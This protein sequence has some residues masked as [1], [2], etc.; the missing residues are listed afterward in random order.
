MAFSI[1]I[2][3]FLALLLVLYHKIKQ[4]LFSEY[5]FS[6][7]FKKVE[8]AQPNTLQ[9]H[10]M[11]L[12]KQERSTPGGLERVSYY[13]LETLTLNKVSNDAIELQKY[14]VGERE[15]QNIIVHFT[16]PLNTKSEVDTYVI[17][18]HY[19]THS[20][21]PGADDNASGVAGLLEIAR[22]LQT[23]PLTN[24]N[25][26]LVF[27]STEELPNFGTKNMGS[28]VHAASAPKKLKLAVVL[29]MIG[30]FS[31]EPNSQRYPSRILKLVYPN[32][33]NFITV[34]S[35]FENST[36]T[37]EIKRRF[38]AYLQQKNIVSVESINAPTSI[39]G[40]DFSDHRN[41]WKFDIPAVMISDTAFYRNRN[42][43]TKNDT[44][45]KLDYER[46]AEV[47]SATILSV[48]WY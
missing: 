22:I 43:H 44:Y 4:P 47:T 6:D 31:N 19:D 13:I 46:M 8:A 26:D 35:N 30:Y 45:E 28:Y 37:K 20:E 38:A 40:I 14:T 24:K 42:Y 5:T 12:S 7:D 33:G 34:A 17:G 41:Y 11:Y 21:L 15:F 16:A 48:L 27:Y 25:I 3:L 1:F 39:R 18:A 29:E 36:E 9:Q 32:K 23:I 10:V 2:L